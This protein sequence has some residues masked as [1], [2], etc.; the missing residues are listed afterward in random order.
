MM[1]KLVLGLAALVASASAF[2]VPARAGTV[3]M[4]FNPLDYCTQLYNSRST[5]THCRELIKNRTLS[6]FT[7]VAGDGGAGAGRSSDAGDAG[8]SSDA[9]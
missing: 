2:H 6:L 3:K 8:R 5:S 9:A 7:C 1:S 4:W